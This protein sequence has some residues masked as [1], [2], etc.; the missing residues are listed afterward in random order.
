MGVEYAILSLGQSND[1]PTAPTSEYLALI[2]E[3]NF[4]TLTPDPLLGTYYGYAVET[5]RFL[6]FY[7]PPSVPGTLPVGPAPAPFAS[8]DYSYYCKWLPWTVLEGT[9]TAIPRISNQAP[10]GFKYPNHFA[11]PKGPVYDNVV[12]PV[13][14][15]AYPGSINSIVDLARR[16]QGWLKKRVNVIHLAVGSTSLQHQ[17]T[18]ALYAAFGK[19]GWFDG[20]LHTNWAPSDAD[21]LAARLTKVLTAAKIATE[22]EGNTLKIILVTM[23]QGETDSVYQYMRELWPTNCPAFIDWVRALVFSLGLA[24][25]AEA[26]TPFVWPKIPDQPWGATNA[27][28]INTVLDSRQA[29]DPY[30]ATYDTNTFTKLVPNDPHFG[31]QGILSLAQAD[32]SAFLAIRSRTSISLPMQ[33][34][35]TL[36]Q[37]RDQVRRVTERNTSDTGQSDDVINEAINEAYLDLIN[38]VADTC[39]WLRQINRI[40]LVSNPLTPVALP[41][42]VTRLLE[43]R[44][45][46]APWTTYD[47]SMVGH[48]DGGRVQII[49]LNYVQELVDLHHMYVPRKMI[50]DDERPLIPSEYIEAVKIGAARRVT[51]SAGN[52]ALESKLRVEEAKLMGLVSIHSNKVDRQ[53]RQ[54]L[55]GG[56]RRMGNNGFLGQF[57]NP[58]YPWQNN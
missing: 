8:Y 12:G 28:A 58:Y 26:Q 2:P 34:V 20:R 36:A 11:M 5:I 23:K 30:F 46:T 43:I 18:N 4:A 37:L 24:V 39:W 29:D 21:A 35:P 13:L 50:A 6:T 19:W 27:A 47:W 17:E 48:T 10:T 56:R 38:Y 14:I 32:F 25:E 7:N 40:T 3:M 49:T 53:R 44:P 15:A 33:D 51:V 55:N 54:R 57:G 16:M 45:A 31:T 42:V 1:E 9:N 41:R 22:A 52:S